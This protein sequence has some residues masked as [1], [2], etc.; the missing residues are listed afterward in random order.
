M[1]RQPA[2]VSKQ[3][4]M[5]MNGLI[6]IAASALVIVPLVLLLFRRRARPGKPAY[7]RHKT[8]LPP[9]RCALY[10]ALKQAVGERFELIPNVAVSDLITPVK[11]TID[12]ASAALFDE[13]A[14]QPF[15]VVLCRP[16]DLA[17]LAA[18][19]VLPR[20]RAAGRGHS[21]GSSLRGVCET[22][23]LPLI[24]VEAAP[25]YEAAALREAVL[26]G[27]RQWSAPEAYADGR[28]EP[29][30]SSLDDLD[31]G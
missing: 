22:A 3:T 28:R 12:R 7:Q 29:H 21:V 14:A 18:V 4:A 17:A 19:A 20:D 26:A 31:L 13:L 16:S 8:A 15:A 23:G 27:L 2:S 24:E 11:G 9:E 1:A 6:V 25:M 10:Q 5:P 30:I